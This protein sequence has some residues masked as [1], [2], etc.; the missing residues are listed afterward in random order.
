MHTKQQLVFNKIQL[1]TCKII[2]IMSLKNPMGNGRV[3]GKW[4]KKRLVRDKDNNVP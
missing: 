3:R 4:N 1:V 2:N